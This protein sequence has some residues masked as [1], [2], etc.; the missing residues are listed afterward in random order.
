MSNAVPMSA[1]AVV[2]LQI[3]A[4]NDRNGNPRRAYV[5]LDTR[6]L[7][8][9]LP[10]TRIRGFWREGYA[11]VHVLPSDLRRY[12]P[13]GVR[14]SASEYRRISNLP[15]SGPPWVPEGSHGPGGDA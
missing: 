10:Y 4:P 6:A 3:A 8:D 13:L 1:P 11:G 12:S 15:V 9:A 2:L 7:P 14:V 5:A